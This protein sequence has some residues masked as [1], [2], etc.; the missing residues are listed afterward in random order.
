V[1]PEVVRLELR[2]PMRLVNQL[3]DDTIEAV[4]DVTQEVESGERN[5]TKRIEVRNLPERTSLTALAPEV[6]VRVRRTGVRLRPAP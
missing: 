6:Q 5:I 4:V 2:G 1:Q 3:S